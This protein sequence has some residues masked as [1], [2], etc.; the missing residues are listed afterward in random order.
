MS[1]RWN[2]NS[3]SLT[4]GYVLMLLVVGKKECFFRVRSPELHVL[5]NLLRKE[6]YTYLD[7]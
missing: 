7:I 6:H 2:V 5:S 1:D 4:F 3:S